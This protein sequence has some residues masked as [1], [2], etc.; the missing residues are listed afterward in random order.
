MYTEQLSTQSIV[1][2]HLSKPEIHNLKEPNS[3]EVLEK[4]FSWKWKSEG[5]LSF[6]LIL[7]SF[8]KR[9]VLRLGNC[10]SINKIF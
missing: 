7:S 8:E 2:E 1:A 4:S 6:R 3:F 10:P 9:V 5:Q